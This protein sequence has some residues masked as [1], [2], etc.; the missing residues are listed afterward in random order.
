MTLQIQQNAYIHSIWSFKN[1]FGLVTII[2][3]FKIDTFLN[4][5]HHFLIPII[6]PGLS[7]K[8]NDNLL[9]LFHSSDLGY[10]FLKYFYYD[11]NG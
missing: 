11:K 3:S 2:P 8:I 4:K 7:E 10:I 1:H 9:E 6:L 5:I